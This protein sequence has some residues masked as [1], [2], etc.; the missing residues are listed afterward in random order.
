MT[1][2]IKQGFCAELLE[3]PIADL[4]PT[5]TVSLC[6]RQGRKYAQILSSIKEI[7]LIEAPVI[8]ELKDGEG[9]LL[10]DGHLRIMA[11]K[12]LGEEKVSCLVSTD[13]ESYT[14]NKHINRLSAIQEHRMIVKALKSGVSEEKLASTLNLDIRT[15]R[16][17]A[18]L[19]KG[20][21]QEVIDMLKDKIVPEPVFGVLRKMKKARQIQVA[22]LMN[23]H[24]KFTFNYAKILLLGSGPNEL[25][26]KGRQAAINPAMLA[27][28]ARLESESLALS[29]DLESIKEEYGTQLVDIT[30]MQAY[31]KTLV[32]NP[33][34][35]NYLRTFNH[36]IYD[37][38]KEI[39]EL[40]FYRLNSAD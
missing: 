21:C 15:I 29:Q 18:H 24:N 16:I 5:K 33:D 20:I 3:L 8:T 13:D 17:K 4:L 6:V 14:Y 39:A 26:N 12:E 9:Y 2:Q 38:F 23:D 34:V 31:L 10:L 27:R 32:E 30:A 35:A 25:V 28:Q 11:L 36:S 22:M 1:N 19:L 7:G 37:K 40:N